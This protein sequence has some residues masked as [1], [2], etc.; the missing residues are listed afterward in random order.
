MSTVN[1]TLQARIERIFTK[2]VADAKAVGVPH[3]PVVGLEVRHRRNEVGLCIP[4]GDGFVIAFSEVYATLDDD[5]VADTLM[6]ELIH[7]C[8]HCLNH[9]QIFHKWA[10]L[11]NHLKGYHVTTKARGA[12][13][14]AARHADVVA[15]HDL[16]V[17]ACPCGCRLEVSRNR[18][19][20]KRPGN[21]LC[22]RHRRPLALA[23]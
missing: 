5:E 18:A 16:V 20:A 12:A 13:Y 11:V 15:K 10:G 19:V 22:R 3:G 23:Q 1:P 8:P 14:Q 21:Y 7:T 17:L 9:G 6:H 4:R 2:V